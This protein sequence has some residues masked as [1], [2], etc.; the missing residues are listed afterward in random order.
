MEK[1]KNLHAGPMDMD[2]G[3][4]LLEGREVPGGRGEKGGNWDNHKSI[5]NKICFKKK[6]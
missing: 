4:G 3:A 1:P 6:Q 2:Y 5:I